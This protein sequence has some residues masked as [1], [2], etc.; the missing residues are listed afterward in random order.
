MSSAW[1]TIVTGRKTIM[2]FGSVAV[3]FEEP[4]H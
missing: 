4:S 1:F 2:N 3:R